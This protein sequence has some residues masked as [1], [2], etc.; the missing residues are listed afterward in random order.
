MDTNLHIVSDIL[1]GFSEKYFIH[2]YSEIYHKTMY[3][4]WYCAAFLS[5]EFTT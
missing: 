1:G 5:A 2:F 3:K 4:Y